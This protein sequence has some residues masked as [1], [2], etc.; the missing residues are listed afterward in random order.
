MI[1]V[2]GKKAFYMARGRLDALSAH[3]RGVTIDLGAGDGRFAYRAALAKPERLFIAID[4]AREHVAE[5]SARAAKNPRFGGAPNVLYVA[6]NIEHAPKELSRVADEILVTLPGGS[7]L[8]GILLGDTALLGKIAGLGRKNA[9]IKMA[10]NARF[11]EEPAPKD[12]TRLPDITP[13]YTRDI[14]APAFAT[15]GV[16]VSKARWMDPAEVAN[17]GT[18]WAKRLSRRSPHRT[19]YIEAKVVN[20]AT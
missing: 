14:I 17:L 13:L 16:R 11:V 15:T 19:F 3:Y 10:I 12:A 1:V 4:P 7:L 6:A 5:V 9:K 20:A 8:R 2:Q 18:T